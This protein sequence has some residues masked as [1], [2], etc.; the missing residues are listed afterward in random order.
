M[1]QQITKTQFAK[2]IGS[3]GRKSANCRFCGKSA[4]PTNWKVRKFADL[5]FPELLCGPPYF[6][7]LDVVGSGFGAKMPSTMSE[8]NRPTEPTARQENINT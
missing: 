3:A 4:N 2:K 5:R 1:D 6:R 7:D 8:S